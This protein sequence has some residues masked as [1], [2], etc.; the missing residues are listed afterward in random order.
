MEATAL[1][2]ELSGRGN[3]MK[4]ERQE[5]NEQQNSRANKAP[6]IVRI[7]YAGNE[8]SLELSPRI[9]SRQPIKIARPQTAI[10]GF[11][12]IQRTPIANPSR[13]TS[14]YYNAS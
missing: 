13:I 14:S 8:H 2:G 7:L 1:F 3:G 11:G 12:M 9:P 4:M 6:E 10:V 5:K